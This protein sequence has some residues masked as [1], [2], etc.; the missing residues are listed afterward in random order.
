MVQVKGGRP[1]ARVAMLRSV[2]ARGGTGVEGLPIG[3]VAARSGIATS[4]IR[5]YERRGLIGRPA[6][7]NG[8]RVFD[9]SVVDQ[10][11]LIALAKRAGFTVAEIKELQGGFSRPTPPGER[12]RSLARA[13]SAE[14]ERRVA[15]AHRMQGV[16]RAVMRCRCPTLADCVRSMRARR[17]SR[18]RP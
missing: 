13:K 15:E 3:E 16:L 2:Q 10:L 5:Y 6:R 12:W 9:E 18:R 1:A 17:A 4:A 11:D 14:L 7:R 8:R